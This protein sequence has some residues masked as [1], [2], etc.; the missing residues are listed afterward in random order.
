IGHHGGDQVI[1]DLSKII[2]S[3]AGSKNQVFRYSGDEFLVLTR[4]T[5]KDSIHKLARSIQAAVTGQFKYN[6]YNIQVTVS[7]G[8]CQAHPEFDLDQTILNADAALFM[9]KRARNSVAFFSESMTHAK[10]RADILEAELSKALD[11]NQFELYY[12]PILDV[13]LK[14]I[15]HAEALLRWNHPE[16]GQ[17]SPGEFIPLAEKTRLIIPMTDWVI[18]EACRQSAEWRNSGLHDLVISVN[19]SAVT[20]EYRS[21]ELVSLILETLD[22]YQVSPTA[23]I[24]EITET[25]LVSDVEDVSAL[26][27]ELKRHGVKLALD[28]FGTGYASFGAL[29]GL[30]LDVIKIDR[31]LIRHLE[32]NDRERMILDSLFTI[33]HG[34]GL[35]VVV[36]G[37]ETQTQFD[38]LCRHGCDFIQGFLIRRPVPVPELLTI[39]QMPLP[40]VTL[41]SPNRI[42][43]IPSSQLVWRSEWQS[44]EPEIDRQ[45]R[46]LVLKTNRLIYFVNEGLL[47]KTELI[48]LVDHIAEEVETHFSYEEQVL[49]EVDYSGYIDHQRMHRKIL[50]DLLRLRT[51]YLAGSVTAV[52]LF[53]FIVEDVILKH[54]IEADRAFFPSIKKVFSALDEQTAT[55][56]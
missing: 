18:R 11:Q 25:A 41:S 15:N 47:V 49:A 54:T 29:N 22:H 8:I 39:V 37:V 42:V 52:E 9:A 51:N 44:G 1:I 46:N 4:D 45:H 10:T 28:D 3:C 6:Q 50:D 5:D 17:I 12:Q 56:P 43:I 34:L 7:I 33:I 2:L 48:R 20:L 14:K 16:F 23:L 55:L 13:H 30:P 36:E 24:L 31:S 32:S 38:W 21:R 27:G 40:V 35:E 53:G 26:F 19:L